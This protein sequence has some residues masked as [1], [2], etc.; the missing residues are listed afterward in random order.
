[1]PK[2]IVWIEDDTD[3]IDPV[4]RPLERAGYEIVRLRSVAEAL[5]AVEQIRAAKL[6]LLD[7]ILPPHSDGREY[8]RYPGLKLLEILQ[9]D[10]GI[11]TPVVAL[12]VVTHADVEHGLHALGVS[13]IVRKPVRPSELKERVEKILRRE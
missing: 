7:M 10:Q 3:I 6:I 1:M 12:T 2:T 8:G 5:N 9:R 11:T 4:V 13:E